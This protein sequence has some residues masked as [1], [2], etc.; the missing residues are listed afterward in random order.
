MS[1]LK[2]MKKDIKMVLKHERYLTSLIVGKAN[3]SYNEIPFLTF[4]IGKTQK[5]DNIL[6]FWGN[7]T[8]HT[9]LLEC[10]LPQPLRKRIWQ[11]VIKVHMHMSFD[12]VIPLLG[13]YPEGIHQTKEKCVRSFLETLSVILQN[14]ELLECPSIAD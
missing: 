1:K 6:K 9:F 10:E 14:T 5:F 3:Q 11:Y 8:S 4:Q 2:I 7:R 12:L 13:I